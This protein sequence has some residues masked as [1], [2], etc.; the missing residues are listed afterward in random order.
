[1]SK[2][3][4]VPVRSAVT[5]KPG[6]PAAQESPLGHSAGTRSWPGRTV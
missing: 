2:M 1:M 5:C 3:K 4:R 6:D